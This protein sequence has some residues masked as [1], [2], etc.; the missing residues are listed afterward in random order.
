MLFEKENYSNKTVL[1]VGCGEGETVRRLLNLMDHATNQRLI[2]TDVVTEAFPD[3]NRE[4]RL[5]GVPIEFKNT[6]AFT[7]DGVDDGSVDIVV[8]CF[9]M[10]DGRVDDGQM[11]LALKRFMTVLKPGGKVFI[12]ERIFHPQNQNARELVWESGNQL[13]HAI[14]LLSGQ[15]PPHAMQP[16]VMSKLVGIVGFLDAYWINPK[17]N[18]AAMN[19]L[20]LFQSQFEAGLKNIK[21]PELV[22]ILTA[23]VYDWQ[24][25]V[26][27]T[28]GLDIPFY[29]LEAHK[30]G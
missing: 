29:S 12:Q 16:E 28:D 26:L 13:L 14:Q 5:K 27:E 2:V 7:L 30:A 25:K 10:S 19:A 15:K 24:C 3:L 20:P 9:S 22:K 17:L 6:N 21:S 23:Q 1:K 8:S 11:M 18:L 4:A